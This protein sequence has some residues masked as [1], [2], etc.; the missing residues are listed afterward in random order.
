MGSL[1]ASRR[2]LRDATR[3]GHA[4]PWRIA[5]H[6]LRRYI[7]PAAILA[8]LILLWAGAVSTFR[9]PFYIVPTP[10]QVWHAFLAEGW[11][12][13]PQTWTTSQEIL[14]G[15]GF[16]LAIG[17]PL[18]AVMSWS[19]VMRSG[20]YP[21]LIGSQMVPLFAIAVVIEIMFSSYA[22]VP[23]I[24]VTT[25]FSFFP[26]VV[27][28]VDGLQ[29]VEPDLVNLLRAA[30]ASQWRIFRTVR[31]PS[32]L[33]S[34]FSGSKLAIT[35]AVGGAAIGEWLGGSSGLGYLIRFQWEQ[36]TQVPA[37]YAS[38]GVLTLLGVVLFG[39]VSVAENIAVP[40]H[41]AQED[42]LGDL[43]RGG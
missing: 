19:R 9:L 13:L 34:I 28:G 39:A 32:A 29:R 1:I 27:T 38:I 30:G 23:Q 11:G 37:M 10:L 18:A 33:P 22:L 41:H 3:A 43:W 7:P 42:G 21:L 40:W 36:L 20:L 35:F 31:V 15:F 6:A 25:L 4:L 12:Y 8:A 26:I 24:V 16:A 2:S 5:A 14:I 17:L